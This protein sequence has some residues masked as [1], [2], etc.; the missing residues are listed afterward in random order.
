MNVLIGVLSVMVWV[1]MLL[2]FRLIKNKKRQVM[3]LIILGVG[4]LFFVFI[5]IDFIK[6]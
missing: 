3:P 5:F 6:N 2:V 4:Y 1:A